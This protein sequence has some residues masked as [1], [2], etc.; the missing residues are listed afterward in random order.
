MLVFLSLDCSVVTPVCIPTEVKPPPQPGKFHSPL[1]FL[2][3]PLRVR[4]SPDVVLGVWNPA[5]WLTR[6]RPTLIV[7]S[8]LIPPFCCAVSLS[9]LLQIDCWSLAASPFFPFTFGFS[10]LWFQATLP[11]GYPLTPRVL[12]TL[13]GHAVFVPSVLPGESVVSPHR[14]PMPN[15]SPCAS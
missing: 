2:C 10:R 15:T 9:D 6:N 3:L 14:I 1:V 11:A 5:C 7:S 12:S 8:R 4:R 13:P